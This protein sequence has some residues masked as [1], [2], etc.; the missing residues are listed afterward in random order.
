MK[1][2][3]SDHDE[4][5]NSECAFD[6]LGTSD[7]LRLG[8]I[9]ELSG[10]VFIGHVGCLSEVIRPGACTRGR[11]GE[12]IVPRVVVEEARGTLTIPGSVL[13]DNLLASEIVCIITGTFL[14][15][16]TPH[17]SPCCTAPHLTL[18]GKKKYMPVTQKYCKRV[19]MKPRRKRRRVARPAYKTSGDAPLRPRHLGTDA[20]LHCTLSQLTVATALLNC[21]TSLRA[22]VT[23]VTSLN[24]MPPLAH[25]HRSL[26][27][28]D[29]L[30]YLLSACTVMLVLFVVV[31]N[32][33]HKTPQSI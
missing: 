1:E 12:G 6:C 13:R 19:W 14:A 11:A 20:D 3:E 10:M 25:V 31:R 15:A 22:L 27:A 30:F 24:T 29:R 9:V 33:S 2:Q 18:F 32:V 21:K 5:S 28:N 16:R 7:T 8:T 26:L 23:D 17:L 4:E